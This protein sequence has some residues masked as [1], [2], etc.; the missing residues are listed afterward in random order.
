M[1]KFTSVRMSICLRVITLVEQYLVCT[2]TAFMFFKLLCLKCSCLRSS[3]SSDTCQKESSKWRAQEKER[4]FTGKS[5][6]VIGLKKTRAGQV[7]KLVR[8][9]ASPQLLTNEKSCGLADFGSLN[10]GLA[11]EDYF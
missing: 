11:V 6:A 1:K 4:L 3:F 2:L 7:R 10:C 9:S 8:M 5:R